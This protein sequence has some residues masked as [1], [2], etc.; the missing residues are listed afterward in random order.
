MR[1]GETAFFHFFCY[2]GVRWH[3]DA[4]FFAETNDF[5]N[6]P[7][8]LR[9]VAVGDIALHGR[10]RRWRDAVENGEVIG[11]NIVVKRAAH[12]VG[13][14]ADLADHGDEAVARFAVLLHIG[15]DGVVIKAGGA[16][17]RNVGKFLQSVALNVR[18]ELADDAAG[19][20]VALDLLIAQIVQ[21]VIARTKNDAAVRTAL[22]NGARLWISAYR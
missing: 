7:V 10:C 22:E 15:S 21:I 1:S 14:R 9:S 13:K 17:W 11:H 5:V 18:S 8:D 16:D 3:G 12:G 19:V 20:K 2:F 4:I 6:Q